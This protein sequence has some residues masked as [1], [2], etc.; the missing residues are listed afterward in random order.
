MNG[1]LFFRLHGA[2][3]LL[4]A[5]TMVPAL[6]TALYFGDG[7][8]SA[9]FMTIG[10]LLL[11][12]LPLWLLLKPQEKNL[13]PRDGVLVVA[14]AW[15]LLSIFGALPYLFSGVIP[16]FPDALFESVSGFSTTGATIL[17]NMEGLPRGILFWRHFT[18]WIG[19]MGVL[20]L[21]LALLPHLSGRTSLLVRTE[22]PGPSLSK[23]VPR[24]GDSAKI[25]YLIYT[26]LTSLLAVALLG[27]GLTPYDALLHA[28]STAGTG[29]FS[30]YTAGIAHFGS[31]AVYIIITVFMFLF[32]IN[33]ALFYRLLAG[34]R[35][36]IVKSE[37]LR[38]YLCIVLVSIVAV[39]LFIFPTHGNILS[40][41]Q[42]SAFH[43]TSVISTTGFSSEG[44]ILWPQTARMLL[45]LLML[46]GACAGSTAGG[47]KIVRFALLCKMTSR[48]IRHTFQPRKMQVVRF[49]G[50]GIEEPML[51]RISAFLF[52][53]VSFI[54]LG[55]LLISFENRFD[56]PTNLS[57]ALACVSNVGPG[58]AMVS[59]LEDFA[60]YGSFAK[61]VLSVLML[62]G[63]L[64]FFPILVLLTPTAW[65]KQ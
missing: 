3:M 38:W 15:I 2:V 14:S 32:G 53:Y 28:F 22:S 64:E 58:F 43:V 12:G 18:L 6:L 13:R 51:G 7:D 24:L 4:E 50:K 39:A 52:A 26:A 1:L 42:D 55:T 47:M 10:I 46:L 30:N 65:R 44:M 8:A 21:T 33:F 61:I 37:E 11:I 36:E 29:G 60:N 54:L 40:S 5:V 9:F 19:G 63:R 34:P 20:V 41:L 57:A 62:A 17:Q 35:R 31:R 45:F 16:H 23:L 25:L 56:M 48:E 49:E 27:A 59:S